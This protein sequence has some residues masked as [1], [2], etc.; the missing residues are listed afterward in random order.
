VIR[1][2][3]R[4]L[5]VVV[6]LALLAAVGRIAVPFT[7][8]RL[9]DAVTGAAGPDPVGPVVLVGAGLGVV[10]VAA[11]CSS[12][13][14][15]ALTRAVDTVLA[16]VRVAMLT[17]VHRL[18]EL[19]RQHF[20]RGALIARLTSDVDQISG[21]LHRGGAFMAVNATH[22]LLAAGLMTYYSG[23]LAL[24]VFALLVPLIWIL[25]VARRRL[26]RGYR[27]VQERNAAVLALT[28][29]T[30][31]GAAI[32]RAYGAQRR[33]ATRLDAAVATQRAAQMYAQR[34]SAYA[35]V[36]GEIL[37]AVITLAVLVRGTV[38]VGS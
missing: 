2:L 12:R 36:I 4:V 34:F 37:V 16:D 13:M 20:Q 10:A 5:P 26:A 30:I 3:R 23:Q 1:R 7:V 22:L 9:V 35:F 18:T 17:H 32:I 25:P 21:F 33:F 24:V 29:E 27:H 6:V 8:Q 15:Y 31:A 19:D 28:E 11:V 14:A 38:L